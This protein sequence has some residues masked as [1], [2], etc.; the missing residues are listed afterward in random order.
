M[1][2]VITFGETMLRLSPPN[3]RR[4]EQVFSYEANAGGAEMS[5]ACNVSRLGL[6]TAW[7]SR[8]T[9]NSIGHFIRNKAREQGVDT[10]HVVW[11]K[12]DRVGIYF[13]EFG[14]SPRPSRVIY[15][16][17]N[18]AMCKVKPGDVDWS[19]ILKGAKWF[20]TTG[21]TPALSESSAAATLE[22]LKMAK[23]AGCKV[24]CDLN[25]RARLWTEDEAHAVMEPLMEYVDVL[26]ST[27]EDTAKVLKITGDSYQDVARKLAEKFNFE[28]VCITIR[29]DLSVLRNNW[30][31]IV[32]SGGKVYEDR[33][34]EVE[35]IDRVGAGDSFASGFLY[36][37]TTGDVDK[38]LRYG[39][40]YAALE[41]SI[42]GDIN[43]CTLQELE[44][45]IKGGGT[46]ISR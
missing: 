41:H 4:I 17:S 15:D 16:R 18:S 42:P 22:A 6:S 34:Y 46:R 30:T 7:V 40:A 19:E 9:D 11:T 36:G 12:E 27:E 21:I 23:A 13:V 26:I 39:N 37:Y 3:Y 8:M 28:A 33:T 31:A 32:Y 2:D 25:Y 20:Y 24:A 44:N 14:A 1:Y 43:W 35:I 5:V 45:L 29:T 10:S 38:G